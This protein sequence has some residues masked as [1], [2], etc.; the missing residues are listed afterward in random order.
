[1]TP[2][3]LT[4]VTDTVSCF[5]IDADTY[6]YFFS[7]S[8]QVFAAIFAI[9]GVAASLRIG[10]IRRIEDI[11]RSAAIGYLREWG[12]LI[13][14]YLE[15]TNSKSNLISRIGQDLVSDT[16]DLKF[17]N[18]TNVMLFLIVSD[19]NLS[20]EKL[21][22]IGRLEEEEYSKVK[23]HTE[24]AL[25]I[26]RSNPIDS[27]ALIKKVRLSILISA[28]IISFSLIA[29]WIKCYC[30]YFIIGVLIFMVIALFYLAFLFI[31]ILKTKT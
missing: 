6:R 29:L 28:L 24:S 19:I 18:L 3:T 10:D 9:I 12:Y 2:D 30:L 16:T 25:S 1:M 22:E 13:Y 27:L 8:A 11:S 4:T 26:L 5:A 14:E 17:E 21:R 15:I 31:S 20:A 23:Y 7:A